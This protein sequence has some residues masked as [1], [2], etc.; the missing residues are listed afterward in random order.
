MPT[1]R[2][3]L[4]GT[5]ALLAASCA[6]VPQ[7]RPG[8]FVATAGTRFNRGGVR[9]RCRRHQHVVRRLP[10]RDAAVRQSR[11][12]EARARPA[13]RA[14]HQQR[15][16]PRL[17]RIFAAQ[18]FGPPDVPRP[19]PALQ[20]DAASRASTS[21]SPKWAGAGMKAVIYLTNF[22]EWSGGMMTYLYWTNGGRYIEHE[23]PGASV[24][25]IPRHESREFYGS[26]AAVA[27]VSRLCPRGGRRA[28]TASPAGSIATIPRSW[29]GSSPTSRGP[30]AAPKRSA[31]TCPPICVDRRHRAADQVDRP[32][33]SGL[34]R[35][36]GHAGLHRERPVRRR[37]ARLARDRLY[38]RAYL[39]AELELGRP[40]GPCR[41]LADGRDATCA[42]ISRSRSRLRARLG[43]PLVIEEFGFPRDGGSFDP[44]TPTTF[45]D[46]FYRLIYRRVLEHMRARRTARR[47]AISGRGAAKAG[48]SMP[49]TISCA[50]TPATSATRRTSRRAGTA[51]S[52][53]M[54]RRGDQR[55][56]A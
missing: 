29:P 23:R 37:R 5:S 56:A 34:D 7:G 26:A 53:S 52:T 13:R 22:W 45:K 10:R 24:A 46:R 15:P 11:S 48:R 20:R 32:Q 50:A 4:I 43:K 35:Q 33:P 49:T 2:D 27:H 51:C 47:D 31:R 3:L 17:V 41:H 12:A 55:H 21:R 40:Q 19:E 1:R 28:P 8:Q 25:G 18:E 16:D 39:A 42:T 6:T 36:R 9:Y 14:R 30:A 44:G 38:D 54:P